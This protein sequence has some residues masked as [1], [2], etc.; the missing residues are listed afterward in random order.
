VNCDGRDSDGWDSDRWRQ[1]ETGGDSD[2]LVCV[3][4][5]LVP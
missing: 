3:S 5:V 4:G 2:R 1:V